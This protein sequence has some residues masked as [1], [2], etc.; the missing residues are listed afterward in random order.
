MTLTLTRRQR[1][2]ILFVAVGVIVVA[3]FCWATLYVVDQRELAVVLQFGNP[4]AERTEPGLYAK[5]PFIQNVRTLPGTRQFWGGG[6]EDVLPDLPTKDGKKIDVTPWAVW[7]INEPIVFVQRLRTLEN[8]EQRV[9]QFVRGAVRDVITQYDLTE[10]VRSTNR[11]LTYSFTPERMLSKVSAEKVQER[12]TE[13]KATINHGR[14]KIL[15]QIKT[16]A[17]RRLASESGSEKDGGGRGIEVIDVGVSQI[18]FVP[19]VREAA[20]DRLI[21]FME[22]IAA[23]YENEGQRE[24]QEILNQTRAEV[25]RIEGEGKQ[26]ANEIRGQADAQIIT[27]Y[28][29]AIE[30]AGEFYTFIRTLEAYKVALGQDSRLILTTDSGFM[31][32]LKEPGSPGP[33]PPTSAPARR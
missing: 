11:E 17:M 1:L 24:K 22:S 8:A 20:F 5:M 30:K 7:R 19:K 13:A 31:R 2:T 15:Q 3:G 32:L 10:I 26:K 6:A 18:D 29:K 28:A 33:T 12:P 14:E 25:E 4:V 27:D 21:A 16:E 23:L 9:A